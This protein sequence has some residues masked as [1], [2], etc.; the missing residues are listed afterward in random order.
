MTYEPDDTA[1]V[2]LPL[3]SLVLLVALPAALIPVLQFLSISLAGNGAIAPGGA[4]VSLSLEAQPGSI[5]AGSIIG[6]L[7]AYV[8]GGRKAMFLAVLSIV[9]AVAA[10]L[11]I[12]S[13]LAFSWG[14]TALNLAAG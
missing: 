12:G 5:I 1:H 8:I 7:V 13:P 6:L 14:R 4:A 3:I 9:V 10:M 2:R 11:A